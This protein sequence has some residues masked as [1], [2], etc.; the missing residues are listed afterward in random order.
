M[1]LSTGAEDEADD[2]GHR[3]VEFDRDLLVEFDARQRFG[4]RAVGLDDD[5][6]LAR[7]LDNAAGQFAPALGN[8]ARRL[9]GAA[10]I[11]QRDR[12]AD[13]LWGV[14]QRALSSN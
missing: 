8:D 5:A 6:G 9:T 2:L 3:F 11:F 1:T 13:G 7:H 4:E 10:L 12:E 14:A